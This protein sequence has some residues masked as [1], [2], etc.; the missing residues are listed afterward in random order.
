MFAV[1]YSQTKD[2]V[3]GIGL[4]NTFLRVY[5]DDTIHDMHYLFNE[6]TDRWHYVAV[7]Y[8]RLFEREVTLQI[9][10]DDTMILSSRVFDWHNFDSP[11]T[12]DYYLHIGRN[13][14]G[15]VRKAKINSRSYCLNSKSLWIETD[16]SNCNKKGDY[17]CVFC[18]IDDTGSGSTYNCFY[19]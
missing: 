15:V 3:L 19:T 18:D 1:Y 2:Y 14:P 7:S 4:S 8:S 16:E 5:L 9:F 13:F 11:N 10:L 12:D 6:T 17:D